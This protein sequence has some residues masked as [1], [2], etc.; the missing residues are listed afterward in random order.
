MKSRRILIRTGPR[1]SVSAREAT[2]T[3]NFVFWKKFVTPEQ[4]LRYQDSKAMKAKPKSR[5][6]ERITGVYCG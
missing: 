2:K 3:E 5:S 6:K 4:A 1:S